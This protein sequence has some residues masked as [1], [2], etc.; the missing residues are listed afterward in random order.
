MSYYLNVIKDNPLG[1]WPLDESVF[2]TANDISGCGNHGLYNGTFNSNIMPLVY[3]GS[4]ATK[5]TNTSSISYN[6]NKNFYKH[7]NIQTMIF[8]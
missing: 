5:I 2:T 8:L 3:G 4:F 1:L 7:P 6:T